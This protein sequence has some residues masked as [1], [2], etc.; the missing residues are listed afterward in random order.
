MKFTYMFKFAFNIPAGATEV[1]LPDNK[2]IVIFAAT[3]VDEPYAPTK[4]VSTL[5]HTA[6][7]ENKCIS[8][9]AELKVNIKSAT[10]LIR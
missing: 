7:K 8:E 9:T 2:N 6:N 4:A 5:F 1:V 3:L 10:A